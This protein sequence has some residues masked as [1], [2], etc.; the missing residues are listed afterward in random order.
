ML[1]EHSPSKRK[2]RVNVGHNQVVVEGQ[3]R[4][5]AIQIARTRLSLEMPRLWDVIFRM[6]DERFHVEEAA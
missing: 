6:E 2:F 3:D 1:P 4:R 5:E